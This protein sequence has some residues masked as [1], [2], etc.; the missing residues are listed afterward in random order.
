L[1][2]DK[3]TRIILSQVRRNIGPTETVKKSE[4]ER[5]KTDE[6][7]WSMGEKKKTDEEGAMEYGREKENRRGGSDGVSARER[8]QTRRE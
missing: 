4:G 3:W 5:K 7:R 8:K 1:K 6:E 2:N